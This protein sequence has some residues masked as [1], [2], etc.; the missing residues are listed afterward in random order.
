MTQIHGLVLLP[1]AEAGREALLAGWEGFPLV[2][3][4][5]CED[6]WL[7]GKPS[8]PWD[9]PAEQGLLLAEDGAL[10]WEGIERAKRVLA[11]HEGLNAEGGLLFHPLP[12]SENAWVLQG[13]PLAQD[14]GR[15]ETLNARYYKDKADTPLPPG[16]QEY[17]VPGLRR[18]HQE[19]MPELHM[20]HALGRIFECH[21]MGRL[22]WLWR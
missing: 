15:E 22:E 20:A 21:A 13:Q 17:I 5:A 10:V 11:R 16:P 3:G 2:H 4:F 8:Y 19:L 6:L 7:R 12:F 1:L 18:R 9:G 14:L